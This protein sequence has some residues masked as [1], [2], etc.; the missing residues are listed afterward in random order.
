M[1]YKLSSRE[2]KLLYILLLLLIV[3]F[4]WFFAINPAL[5]KTNAKQNQLATL[6][7]QRD[8]VKNTYQ[9][10]VT[11]KEGL[12]TEKE[13]SE[14]MKGAYLPLGESED[15]DELLTGIALRYGLVPLNLKIESIKTADNTKYLEE[16]K[17]Q[18]NISDDIIVYSVK[19]NMSVSGELSKVIAMG[20]EIS[21]ESSYKMSNVFYD[22]KGKDK[23]MTL[24]FDVYMVEK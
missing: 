2:I 8:N 24:S 3:V 4:G 9:S 13:K 1:N 15:L 19:V 17:K 7:I 16:R 23:K 12:I 14:I 5:E 6:E 20:D 21:Q 10:Y 11:A 18:G 22:N